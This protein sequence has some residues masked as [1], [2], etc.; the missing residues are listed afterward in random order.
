[1]H[2][3]LRAFARPEL[4]D[5]DLLRRGQAGVEPPRRLPRGEPHRF[6]VDVGVGGALADRLERRDRSAEL[7]AG[8][9]VVRG[10]LERRRARA[11]GHHAHRRLRVLHQPRH[12][13]GTGE[14]F[15]G[16]VL[17]DDP[18]LGDARSWCPGVRR[19]PRRTRDRPRTRPASAVTTIRA[20]STPAGTHTF[21]PVSRPSP[22]AVVA[23]ANAS[24]TGSIE[25][26]GDDAGAVGHA[27][28]VLDTAEVRQRASPPSPIT[29]NAGTGA[30]AR[31]TSSS[32]MHVSRKPRPPP[33]DRLR[34][35]DPDEAGIGHR[36]PQLVV[37]GV[38]RWRAPPSPAR[39]WR[40]RRGSGAPAPAARPGRRRTRGPCQRLAL[41]QAERELRDQVTLRL[42]RAAAEREDERA[43]VHA[44]RAGS[45]APR[46]ARRASGT[47]PRRAPP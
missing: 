21:S 7:L 28:E 44:P 14:P 20:A 25:R 1:M 40:R 42:V 47:R 45:A 38:R 15:G 17:Q 13:F 24:P 33:P 3:A 12:T 30:A 36:A 10:E 22:S 37:D 2:D 9:R 35:R 8:L 6:G 5:G 18:R 11:R 41:G 19:S 46:P 43:A 39:G 23:G 31:P 27:V 32:T 29:A 16:R 34:Q 26:G 4:G